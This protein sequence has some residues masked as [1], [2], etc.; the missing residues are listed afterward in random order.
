MSRIETSFLKDSLSKI[1]DSKEL[2]Q[3]LKSN[4]ES[5]SKSSFIEHLK[6]TIGDVNRMQVDAD[7]LS[8][9]VATGKSGNL[10][11]AMLAMSQAQLGFNF[12]VQVRNKALEA[13]NE[14][15]RMQV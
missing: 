10:H 4:D 15:M 11:E 6:E 13:Y 5:S 1:A 2:M 7:K 14:V 12:V 3:N 9:D 8:V